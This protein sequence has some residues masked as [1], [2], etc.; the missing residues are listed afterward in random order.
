MF[1]LR[2]LSA[3]AIPAALAKAERYRLLNE[4]GQAES[5]CQDVLAV[6]PDNQDALAMMILA[7]TDQFRDEGTAVHV[8]R[9]ERLVSGLRDAYT[10]AYYGAII[11]ERRARAALDAGRATMAYE[12]LLGA[13]HGFDRAIGLRPGRQ[14]RRG[15][16]VERVRA[17]APAPAGAGAGRS[18]RVGDHVGVKDACTTS[19]RIGITRPPRSLPVQGQ[20]RSGGQAA[21]TL[22]LASSSYSEWI[23][24]RGRRHASATL[25]P[26]PGAP[27]DE[28]LQSRRR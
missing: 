24:I 7:I 8:G 20:D 4:S 17:R 21:W 18:R 1:E 28:G 16:A 5:I 13:L 27:P 9:A 14:R 10:Q 12:W 11:N 3:A 23:R 15:A 2:P 19:R 26:C 25:R 6:D 22:R